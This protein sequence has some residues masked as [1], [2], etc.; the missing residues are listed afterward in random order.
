M[1]GLDEEKKWSFVDPGVRRGCARKGGERE[2]RE[3]GERGRREGKA[4][5]I[6]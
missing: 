3:T 4:R 5:E 6:S 2:E 1:F